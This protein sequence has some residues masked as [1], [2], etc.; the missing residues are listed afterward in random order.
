MREP[1]ARFNK[2]LWPADEFKFDR[3]A[4][5]DELQEVVIA[6]ATQSHD[7]QMIVDALNAAHPYEGGQHE[8]FNDATF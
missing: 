3:W 4:I 7:A 5:C 2:I 8:A 1:Q 6:I